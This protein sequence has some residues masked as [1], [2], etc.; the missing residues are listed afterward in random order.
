MYDKISPFWISGGCHEMKIAFDDFAYA[1]TFFG[2]PGRRELS[3]LRSGVAVV[4]RNVAEKYDE[5][6]S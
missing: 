4:V 2:F 3:V 1:F 5:N 6:W